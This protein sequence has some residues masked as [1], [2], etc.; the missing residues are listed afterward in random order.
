MTEQE[1]DIV[2]EGEIEQVVSITG[3]GI[4][5]IL[6]DGWR[7][8]VPAVGHLAPKALRRFDLPM[9]FYFGEKQK[10]AGAALGKEDQTQQNGPFDHG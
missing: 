5:R 2:G 7:G 4:V 8:D 6:K 9:I 1:A 10:V 3:R